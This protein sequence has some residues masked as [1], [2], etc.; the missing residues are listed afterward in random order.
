MACQGN[1]LYQ[2]P[3][4]MW[5]VAIPMYQLPLK[6]LFVRGYE[7]KQVLPSNQVT[8][9]DLFKDRC[10]LSS[11]WE[12]CLPWAPIRAALRVPETELRTLALFGCRHYVL[13]DWL[14]LH[15]TMTRNQKRY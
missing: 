13:E 7:M 1:A 6:Y 8:S 14:S 11:V 4:S 12:R 5:Q 9:L 10:S 2:L 3:T 15:M